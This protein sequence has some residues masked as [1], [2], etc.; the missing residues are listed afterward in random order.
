MMPAVIA[1]KEQAFR[2]TKKFSM[3]AWERGYRSAARTAL[4][5]IIE[6]RMNHWVNCCLQALRSLEVADGS[7]VRSWTVNLACPRTFFF[8]MSR[9][10]LTV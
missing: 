2:E 4:K 6:K 9:E 5:E 7:K 3:D 10:F 1:S 8:F